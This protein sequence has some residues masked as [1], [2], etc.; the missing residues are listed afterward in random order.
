MKSDGIGR[1]TLPRTSWL[2]GPC[3]AMI[4]KSR[5][6]LVTVTPSGA[7]SDSRRHTSPVLAA[8][9]IR[10][11]SSSPRR[12]WIRSSTTPP[13]SSS[14]HSV[15]CAFPGAILPRSLL[16][17]ELT[18]AAA[19]GPDTVAL[20]RWLTSKTPTASRTA[21]CS[22]STPPPAYSS[23]ISQPPNSA[24][25][26]PRA[27]CRSC[28]GDRSS[29]DMSATLPQQARHTARASIA[30]TASSDDEG[31]SVTTISLSKAAPHKTRADALVVGVV[32]D[33]TDV[34][35]APGAEEVAGAFGRSF[36][37]TCRSLGVKGSVGEVTKIPS[38]GAVKA[39]V[40]VLVGLG[41]ADD[42][43]AESIRRAV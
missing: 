15:Y 26:A 20:P 32:K 40:V 1:P 17:Q 6:W 31:Y 2:R 13:V 28:R 10:K 38:G 3:T 18:N 21:A 11:T 33:G 43:T 5:C 41:E 19:P 36:A 42:V 23:G 24:V 12:Y 27:A 4:A 30:T 29:S 39:P 35:V 37:A 22:F 8:L 25:F 7:A 34:A 16:R 9:G 14:Q